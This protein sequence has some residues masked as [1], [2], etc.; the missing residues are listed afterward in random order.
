MDLYNEI[1]SQIARIE[2]NKVP[3]SQLPYKNGIRLEQ[4]PKNRKLEVKKPDSNSN[5][6]VTIEKNNR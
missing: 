3:I 4:T 6:N 2:E 5:L 1:V